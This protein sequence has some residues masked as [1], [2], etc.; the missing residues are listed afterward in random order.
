M[1]HMQMQGEEGDSLALDA[2]WDVHPYKGD[3]EEFKRKAREKI[4]NFI[5]SERKKNSL[6]FDAAT[7]GFESADADT[8]IFPS[9][10]MGLFDVHQGRP[11]KIY[12][13]NAVG[14]IQFAIDY[15]CRIAR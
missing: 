2:S 4:S 6:T 3:Y 15:R 1:M 8:W 7:D 5:A 9:V 13:K 11:C 10:Q 12:L 14:S